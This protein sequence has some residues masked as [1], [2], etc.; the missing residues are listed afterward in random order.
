MI[1]SDRLI[2]IAGFVK[3]DTSVLDI[4][5][6]HGYIPIYLIEN[7]ISKKIIA[8][9]IS[10]N[11]LNKTIEL[12][13]SK[14]LER[15]I[16]SRLGDGL[17]VISPKE[18]QGVIMAGMGGILIQNILEK[19]KEITD[20]IDYFIFQPMI[21][22]K[23]L[24]KYL[25]ENNFKIVDE[26]LAREGDKFYEIIYAKRGNEALKEEIYYEI[27]E[28]LIDKK[29]PLLIDFIKNKIEITKPVLNNLKDK[30][31]SRSKERYR[32]LNSLVND[33]R[34]ALKKIEA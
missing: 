2:K 24:R 8:S 13:K 10:K 5:T 14:G 22:S 3:E 6:D 30:T 21:A 19:D 12:V 7:N 9:D 16:S 20:S 4:G 29:H 17:Q 27:G 26:E 28:K 31:S 33:Y 23:E 1:L 32:E 34:E 11:S 18:V 25:V 15:Y